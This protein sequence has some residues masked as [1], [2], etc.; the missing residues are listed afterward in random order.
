MNIEITLAELKKALRKVTRQEKEDCLIL[1]MRGNLVNMYTKQEK[2]G[3]KG[4]DVGLDNEIERLN[5]RLSMRMRK[6]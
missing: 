3:G 6:I 1:S 5:L 2:A 4:F